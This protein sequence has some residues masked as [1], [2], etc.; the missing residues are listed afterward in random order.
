[1]IFTARRLHCGLLWYDCGTVIAVL[2]LVHHKPLSLRGGLAPEER[3]WHV[4][5]NDLLASLALVHCHLWEN[6]SGSNKCCG[7]EGMCVY[8]HDPHDTFLNF[9]SGISVMSQARKGCQRFSGT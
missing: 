2:V 8:P 3:Q 6:R 1:M 4:H 5:H 7:W 9:N